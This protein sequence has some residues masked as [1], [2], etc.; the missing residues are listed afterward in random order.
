[1]ITLKEAYK[2]VC[3]NNKGM[4]PVYCVE[5]EKYYCFNITPEIAN[6]SAYIVNKRTGRHK[7]AHFTML[8]D[9]PILKEFDKADLKKLE[10]N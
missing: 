6:S 5:L 2:I 1:M 4:K 7:W 3:E 10:E 8:T 9:K